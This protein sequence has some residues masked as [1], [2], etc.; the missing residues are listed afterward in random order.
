MCLRVKSNLSETKK[1]RNAVVDTREKRKLFNDKHVAADHRVVDVIFATFE[2]LLLF[3]SSHA[4]TKYR[5]CIVSHETEFTR[6]YEARILKPI[7]FAT[8]VSETYCYV[9]I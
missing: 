3:F 7:T 8:L 2:K 5:T 6:G 4:G 1:K 9:C